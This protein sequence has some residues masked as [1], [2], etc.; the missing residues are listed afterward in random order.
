M[1]AATDVG[2][3]AAVRR[4]FAQ[5]VER[6]ERTD[7]LVNAA[8]LLSTAQSIPRGMAKSE[9]GQPRRVL[10]CAQAVIPIMSKQRSGR[11]INIASVA[12]MRGGGTVGNA[13]TAQPKPASWP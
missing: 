3:A 1:S 2:D 12:A 10:Y 6:A 9:R 4:L 11:I 7:I 8:G 13:L 5:F